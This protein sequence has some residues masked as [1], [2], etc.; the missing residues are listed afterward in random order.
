MS[1]SV[2]TNAVRALEILLLLG[3]AS[4]DGMALAEIARRVGEAKPTV[5]RSLAALLVKGFAEPTGRHGHYRLGPAVS[6][7]ASR[8]ARLEPV[9]AKHRPGLAHFARETGFT[10]YVMVQAGMDAVCAEMVSRSTPQ[11]FWFGVG[12]R[13]PMGVAAGSIA[14]MSMLPEADCLRMIESNAARYVNHPS[15]QPVDSAVVSKQVDDTR[16]RGYAVNMGYYL[17]GEGGIGLPL[18]A[19]SPFETD[20]AVS[21][22]VPLEIMTDAWSE[23]CVRRLRSCLSV[24]EPDP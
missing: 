11:H 24:D 21:F 1:S 13:V 20:V 2:S 5:H 15:V 10:L 23:E 7:L 18:R 8:Q 17:L 14:L 6:M 16:R 3:D 9:I 12:G 19:A 4:E 22:N